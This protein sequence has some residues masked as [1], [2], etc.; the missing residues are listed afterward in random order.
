MADEQVEQQDAPESGGKKKPPFLAAIVVAVLMIV[1]GAGIFIV[2]KLTSGGPQAA[3][4]AV[5]E[6]QA[7]AE[8]ESMQ[9]ILL[10]EDKFQNMQSGRVWLWDTQ[11]Y[12]KVRQKNASTVEGVLER[13][14]A[15]V[16]EGI[17]MIFRKAQDR[18][19]R[20]PGLETIGRQLKSYVDEVF[21]TDPDG[22][23]RVDRIIVPTMQGFPADF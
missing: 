9:E 16:K 15:E 1:E 19:L 5:L 14:Q 20:E 8:A 22:F 6:G 18:H 7:E 23:A 13:R 12:L 3:D 17:A 10:V 11:I 4:A 2:L 21:G